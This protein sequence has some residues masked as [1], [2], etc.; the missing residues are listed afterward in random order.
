MKNIGRDDIYDML[1]ILHLFIHVWQISIHVH[2]YVL[3]LWKKKSTTKTAAACIHS[4]PRSVTI[5]HLK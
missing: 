3:L 1:R 2:F 4:S 5:P